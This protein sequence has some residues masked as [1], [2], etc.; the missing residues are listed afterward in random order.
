M[1]SIK[2][3]RA[4]LVLSFSLTALCY[5]ELA[6]AQR[7]DTL[8]PQVRKYLKVS[9]PKVVLEHVQIIDGTGAPPSPDQNIY[10]EGGNRS[11][12]RE[13]AAGSDIILLL[14]IFHIYMFSLY[15]IASKDAHC[16]LFQGQQRPDLTRPSPRRHLRAPSRASISERS[17]GLI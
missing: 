6:H 16:Q 9:T 8:A 14:T 11:R 17:S 10:I 12:E 2:T 5:C 7:V 1:R 13:I 15:F 4:A 3:K